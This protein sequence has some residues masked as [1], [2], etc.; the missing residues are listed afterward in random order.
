MLSSYFIGIP[1]LY[2]LNFRKYFCAKREDFKGI[3]LR[4]FD[5]VFMILSYSLDVRHVPLRIDF[6]ILCFH[7]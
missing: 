6:L 3:V 7:I 5:G 2:F 1:V 4:D